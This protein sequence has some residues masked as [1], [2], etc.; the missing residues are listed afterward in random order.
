MSS[1]DTFLPGAY[2]MAPVGAYPVSPPIIS[3]AIPPSGFVG[4]A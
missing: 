3:S 2:S 4:A 1:T